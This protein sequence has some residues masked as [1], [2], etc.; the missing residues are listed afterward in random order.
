LILSGPLVA[1]SVGNSACRDNDA[2]SWQ[3]CEAPASHDGVMFSGRR[4]LKSTQ[5]ADRGFKSLP[6]D[7]TALCRDV[8]DFGRLLEL[9]PSMGSK[10]I[11]GSR[12]RT[13]AHIRSLP[14]HFALLGEYF[15]RCLMSMAIWIR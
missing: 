4:F 11:T 10:I 2:R 15:L 12:Q 13:A 6:R 14:A 3:G 1:W 7:Y 8:A 9:Q 5:T